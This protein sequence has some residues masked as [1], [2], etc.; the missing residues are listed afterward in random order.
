MFL[1]RPPGLRSLFPRGRAT[2]SAFKRSM[3]AL[4]AAFLSAAPPSR[5]RRDWDHSNQGNA[6]YDK[7]LFLLSR[8]S[9]LYRPLEKHAQHNRNHT[10]ILGR[11]AAPPPEKQG[12]P[13]ASGKA[14]NNRVLIETRS[15]TDRDGGH[16]DA[17]IHCTRSR[18]NASAMGKAHRPYEIGAKGSV[19]PTLVPS[20]GGQ[21]IAR[22]KTLL[23][24]PYDGHT[25]KTV[26]VIPEIERPKSASSRRL[27]E[28]R[29]RWPQCYLTAGIELT[30]N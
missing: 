6:A 30:S 2:R 25:L 4:P 8:N 22:D 1:H 14:E 19:A 15:L 10:Q 3:S 18:S 7:N 17:P 13:C 23:G 28:S 21:F 29:L 12:A 27:R 16:D 11:N 26:M 20:K 5:A 24:N 9:S